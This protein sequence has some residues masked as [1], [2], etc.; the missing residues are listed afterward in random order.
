MPVE[1]SANVTALVTDSPEAEVENAPFGSYFLVM[2]HNHSLDQTICEQ[3][4]NRNEFNYF[5]LIG[6]ETKRT[7]FEQRFIQHGFK[8]QQFATM[9]CP[10]GIKGIRSKQPEAIA[11]SIAGDLLQAHD[12]IQNN[13][14][15]PDLVNKTSTDSIQNK[16]LRFTEERR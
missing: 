10:V 14:V 16:K 6:S 5:G 1:L 3:I 15:V 13:N 9:R 11:I 7:R 2:T 4:L 8:R 12:Q